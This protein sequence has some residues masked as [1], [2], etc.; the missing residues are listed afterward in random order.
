MKKLTPSMSLHRL[1]L[2]LNVVLAFAVIAQAT[3]YLNNVQNERLFTLEPS[4][5]NRLH[6]VSLVLLLAAVLLR[7]VY[8]VNCGRRSEAGREQLE[9]MIAMFSSVKHKLNNDMQ[10][11][12]GNAELAEILVNSGGDAHKPVSNITN[13]ANVAV[14]R[15]E[16]LSVFGSTG[17]TNPR[18]IDLNA[19]LRESMAGLIEELPSIVTLRMELGQLS[20]RAVADQHL[21]SLSLSHLVKQAASSM[22]HGG[23]VVVRTFDARVSDQGR[24]G[25]VNAEIYLVRAL[26]QPDDAV[27]TDIARLEGSLAMTKALVERSGVT[28]VRLSRTGDESLFAMRFASE[29]KADGVRDDIVVS[30]LYG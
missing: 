1:G 9:A 15:I 14:E 19:M 7:H 11:V 21:L 28:R 17:Y 13:A 23:E 27:A 2:C 10:V 8:Q 24:D 6:A 12:L 4:V 16:Q 3:L 30:E 20:C 26:T 18:P 5:E 29:L 22:R 25:A